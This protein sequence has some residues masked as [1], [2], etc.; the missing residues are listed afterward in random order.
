MRRE[1]V[2]EEIRWGTLYELNDMYS[3]YTYI[4]LH[5]RRMSLKDLFEEKEI[6]TKNGYILTDLFYALQ[7]VTTGGKGSTEIFTNVEEVDVK[8][9]LVFKT[10]GGSNINAYDIEWNKEYA[11]FPYLIDSEEEKFIA[12]FS[13]ENLEIDVLDFDINIEASESGK[14]RKQ[15][16][17]NRIARGHVKY[18]TIAEYLEKHYNLLYN[19]EFEGKSI[20]DYNK[21]WYEYHRPRVPKILSKEKIVCRRL[22][23]EPSFAIDESGYL[24][25]DSVVSLIPK[26]DFQAL[27]EEISAIIEEEVTLK[28][29]FNYILSF[30]NSDV[31]GKILEEKR[32]KKRGGYPIVS[33]KMLGQV[34]IPKPSSISAD[35]LEA[36]INRAN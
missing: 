23:K 27:L 4:K 11:I 17:S 35:D 3:E 33:D 1:D 30:L 25:R 28:Q 16:L 12:A 15:K 26:P 14:D 34:V 31:F 5:K 36:R 18:P 10:I 7:G 20:L 22:M 6:D 19:R 8:C 29:G 32:A 21:S 13:D 24:P 9:D 2:L